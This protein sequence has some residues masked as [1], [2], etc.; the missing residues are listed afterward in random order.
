MHNAEILGIEKAVDDSEAK[1]AKENNKE[2]R[3]KPLLAIRK[4]S[5]FDNEEEE[6]P[7]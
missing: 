3:A 2:L 7:A 5:I 6:E 1:F 4:L